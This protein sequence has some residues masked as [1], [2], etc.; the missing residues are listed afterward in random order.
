[1]DVLRRLG[2]IANI[3][4]SCK[5]NNAGNLARSNLKPEHELPPPWRMLWKCNTLALSVSEK[6]NTIIQGHVMLASELTFLQPTLAL[7][8]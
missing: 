5:L 3:S 4:V 2:R 7:Y 8:E 6:E 1:M